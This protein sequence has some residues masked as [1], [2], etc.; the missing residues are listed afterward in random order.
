VVLAGMAVRKRLRQAGNTYHSGFSAV[1]V[2][3]PSTNMMIPLENGGGIGR[4][5]G[6]DTGSRSAGRAGW[7]K[8]VAEHPGL[9][10]ATVSRI[11]SRSAPAS[12]IS[13]RTQGPGVGRGRKCTADLH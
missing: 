2:G 1:K 12:R 11:L 7:L 3:V 10:V 4:A 13:T 8:E 5:A 9:S 6:S